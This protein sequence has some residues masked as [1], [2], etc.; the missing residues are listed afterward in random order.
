YDFIAGNRVY[1]VPNPLNVAWNAFTPTGQL[2]LA[3]LYHNWSDSDIPPPCSGVWNNQTDIPLGDENTQMSIS[4]PFDWNNCPPETLTIDDHTVITTLNPGTQNALSFFASVPS[5]VGNQ[6]I[7]SASVMTP[8]AIGTVHVNT[9]VAEWDLEVKGLLP[10][11]DAENAF[12]YVPNFCPGNIDLSL[13]TVKESGNMLTVTHFASGAALVELGLLTVPYDYVYHFS[14]PVTS[15]N[16]F[17]VCST[18]V[19]TGYRCDNYPANENSLPFVCNNDPLTSPSDQH[20]EMNVQ[21]DPINITASLNPGYS[22]IWNRCVEQGFDVT[23]HSGDAGGSSHIT[24]TLDFGNSVQANELSFDENNCT[25]TSSVACGSIVFSA[26]TVSNANGIYTLEYHLED[27]GQDYFLQRGCDLTFHFSLNPTCDYVQGTETTPFTIS[28][29]YAPYCDESNPVAINGIISTNG[30]QYGDPVNDLCQCN[31]ALAVNIY[32][33]PVLCIGGCATLT[34]NASG[35]SGNYTYSWNNGSTSNSYDECNSDPCFNTY[36]VTVDDGTTT[37]SASVNIYVVDNQGFDC[38]IPDNFDPVNDFDFSNK[39]VAQIAVDYPAAVVWNVNHYEIDLLG[40]TATILIN[41]IFT[42]EED[43]SFLNCGNVQMG[44]GAYIFVQP[45]ITLITNSSTFQACSNMW[46]QVRLNGGS[47]LHSDGSTF[48]DAVS[49]ISATGSNVTLDVLSSTFDQN[50]V[51]IEV[52][53]GSAYNVSLQDNTFDCTNTLKD[54]YPG[55]R[56]HMHVH[57]ESVTDVID[58]GNTIGNRFFNADYG[59]FAVRSNI[60]ANNNSFTNFM[61]YAHADGVAAFGTDCRMFDFGTSITV[62]NTFEQ[63][64]Y[65]IQT[66]NSN[67]N[68]LYNTFNDIQVGINN[69]S[70]LGRRMNIQF[71]IMDEVTTGILSAGNM[72]STINIDD[73]E[74]TTRDPLLGSTSHGIYLGAIGPYQVNTYNIYSNKVFSNSSYGIQVENVGSVNVYDNTVEVWHLGNVSHG[75][76]YGIRGDGCGKSLFDHNCVSRS[77]G[78]KLGTRGITLGDCFGNLVKCNTTADTYL[79]LQFIGACDKTLTRGNTISD[80]EQ[81]F[82]M[83][84]PLIPAITKIADQIE[85]LDGVWKLVGNIYPTAAQY[86]NVSDTYT[87]SVPLVNVPL[88]KYYGLGVENDHPF[89]NGGFGFS[90]PI[91][92]IFLNYIPYDR[93]RPCIIK[94]VDV[95]NPRK[96]SEVGEAE[97]IAQSSVGNTEDGDLIWKA[98]RSL[99]E[100]LK[101]DSGLLDSSTVVETFFDTTGMMAIGQLSEANEA[102][103]IL[104]DSTVQEDSLLRQQKISEASQKTTQI[105]ASNSPEANEKAVNEIYINSI[106][107]GRYEFTESEISMLLAIANQCPYTGGYAVYYSRNLVRMQNGFSTFKDDLSCSGFSARKANPEAESTKFFRKFNVFPNPTTGILTIEDYKNTDSKIDF[108]IENSLGAQSFFKSLIMSEGK[109]QTDISELSPG[110]YRYRVITESSVVGSGKIVVIK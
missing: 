10:S 29:A 5:S 7:P 47:Q 1:N 51:D 21:F 25:L 6:I 90:N 43:F 70:S 20:V 81:G 85:F 60:W 36:T 38:C 27:G 100:E 33:V 107:Q 78:N 63:C 105:D 34:A 74:I 48:R 94:T 22:S 2:S 97:D 57:I 12:I 64:V 95:E 52:Q 69:V 35:G 92:P 110:V 76:Q 108:I 23:I 71:N 54:P 106:G 68:L 62:L 67:C 9:N 89:T 99:Y 13:L 28:V 72:Q 17:G 109:C 83:G 19:Y 53:P 91:T 41:G 61:P 40:S 8:E 18:F 98:K 66:K 16:S 26:P 80:H 49:A 30:W 37:A 84:D 104:A 93:C 82:V 101:T 31:G 102:I 44:P 50:F 11:I 55:V 96:D 73:N 3:A 87:Y 24:L 14:A 39:N 59:V 79:G 45:N 15:C 88:Y 4:I 77:Q 58:I 75:L 42:V 103:A 56:T 65:G 46:Q 86:Q 32:P